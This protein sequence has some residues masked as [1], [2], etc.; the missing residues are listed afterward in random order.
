MKMTPGFS[1]SSVGRESKR[2]FSR[3]GLGLLVLLAVFVLSACYHQA[4]YREVSQT[5]P[6][7][8]AA[9][10]QA[11]L[12]Q[13]YFYPK[14][15]QTEEQQSRDHFE[16]YNWAVKQTG[17]DPG[18]SSIPIEQRIQVVPL[19]PPGF[20][21]IRMAIAGAVLGALIGGHRHAGGG[22]LIGAAGGAFAGAMSEAARQEQARQME[23][24]YA[25]ER[26][27]QLKGQ[28]F[29]FRRAMSACLEGRGY[30]VK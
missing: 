27:A 3:T 26:Q 23:E 14:E 4:P 12:T 10:Q 2:R 11:P 17:F 19:P 25:R 8:K 1:S 16:C 5:G 29:R 20:E 21:T 15:G 9:S 28:E 30:T 13:I 22:A 6:E 24:S 7:N 18:R